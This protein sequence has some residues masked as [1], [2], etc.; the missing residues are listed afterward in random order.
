MYY[1]IISKQVQTHSKER[2]DWQFLNVVNAKLLNNFSSL[3]P[4]FASIGKWEHV[5]KTGERLLE[6][7]IV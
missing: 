7:E 3:P 2:T 6:D 4:A 1:K 5:S